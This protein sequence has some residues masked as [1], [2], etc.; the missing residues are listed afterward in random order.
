MVKDGKH[1]WIA[2]RKERGDEDGRGGR[3]NR[4]GERREKGKS[5]SKSLN[6]PCTIDCTRNK[7]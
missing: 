7:L 3:V 6:I 4:I 2:G 1:K 5:T